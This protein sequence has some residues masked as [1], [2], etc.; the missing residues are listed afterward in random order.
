MLH[1]VYVPAS[2]LPRSA[3]ARNH[4]TVPGC[5]RHH[6]Q[7]LRHPRMYRHDRKTGVNEKSLSLAMRA[8]VQL[9]L[10]YADTA[11]AIRLSVDDRAKCPDRKVWN[12]RPHPRIPRTMESLLRGFQTLRSGH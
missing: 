11:S 3:S 5:V 1:R 10:T 2:R 6:V 4:P 12:P 7:K 9:Q 8:T